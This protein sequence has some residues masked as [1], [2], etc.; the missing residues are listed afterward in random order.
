MAY[1]GKLN[2]LWEPEEQIHGL[3]QGEEGIYDYRGNVQYLYQHNMRIP[4][5]F[6]VSDKGYGI[7]VDCGSLIDF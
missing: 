1:H 7:L 2:F 6:L 4:I 5:P 3:G